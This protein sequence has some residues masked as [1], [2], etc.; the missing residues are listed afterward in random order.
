MKQENAFCSGAFTLNMQAK[1]SVD[2]ENGTVFLVFL[3]ALYENICNKHFRAVA[4]CDVS[5]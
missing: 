3:N 4:F 5:Q 1:R 2:V